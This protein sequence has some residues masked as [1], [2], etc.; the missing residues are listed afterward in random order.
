MKKVKLRGAVV[1]CGVIATDSH[2]PAWRRMKHVEIVSVCDQRDNI[3]K[4]SARRWGITGV[5]NDFSQ[6]LQSEK[7]DFVDICTPPAT[8]SPLSIQAMEAGL[9]VLVEKPMAT[10]LS[11]ADRMISASKKY[12][13]KLCVVHNCLFTPVVHAAKS[14]VEAGAIGDML[15]VEV[16]DLHPAYKVLKR[17]NH[18]SYDL[19]GGILGEHAPHMV[20]LESAFLGKINSVQA[21]ARKESKSPRVT[22][23]ELKVLV[24]AENGIGACTN[25]CNSNKFSLTLDIFGTEGKLHLDIVTQTMTRVRSRSNRTH[26]LVLSQL[27]LAL[28]MLAGAASV[29]VNSLL[30]QKWYKIGHRAIIQKFIES[31]QYNLKPPVT[32]ED[33][34]ETVRILEEIW[35]QIGQPKGSVV[36]KVAGAIGHE[37]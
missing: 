21:I 20:Y 19:P 24:E 17:E 35:K 34:R 28:Q 25:S 23:D 5:Y 29:S 36:K 18:W 3:A 16:H 14:M 30:G 37:S 13:V 22:A 8:H 12:G 2:M 6:M 15:A 31:V 26:G 4:E 7:L 33:G 10:L 27:D 9:H 11:E 32:G 1:G